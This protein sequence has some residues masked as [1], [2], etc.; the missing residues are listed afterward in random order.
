MLWLN[1]ACWLERSLLWAL[2]VFS[3]ILLCAPCPVL[4]LFTQVTLSP[5]RRQTPSPAHAFGEALF[6]SL[7]PSFPTAPAM[8]PGTHKC[9][10]LQILTDGGATGRSRA[11]W[12]MLCDEIDRAMTT[13][14]PSYIHHLVS[15]WPQAFQ[16]GVIPILHMWKLRYREGKQLAPDPTSRKGWS[17]QQGLRPSLRSPPEGVGGNDA[18]WT[19]RDPDPNG[20]KSQLLNV[21][22][23]P[24][25]AV[26]F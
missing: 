15:P 9:L 1:R 11:F 5:S 24:A 19:I 21:I 25:R 8:L 6:F 2:L 18:M 10:L 23:G 26:P 4:G 3:L 12:M 14:Q 7:A 20:D 16:G 17:Q 13:H 22:N